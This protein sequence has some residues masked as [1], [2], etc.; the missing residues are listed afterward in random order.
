MINTVRAENKSG[1]LVL[2]ARKSSIMDA[3][4]KAS[5]GAL[6]FSLLYG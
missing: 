4:Y 2:D 1:K 5:F 6:G 3:K